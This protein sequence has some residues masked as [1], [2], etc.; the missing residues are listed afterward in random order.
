MRSWKAVALLLLVATAACRDDTVPV[1]FRPEVGAVYRYEVTV[2]SRS[3]V[4]LPGEEPEVHDEEITLQSKQ[5][6]LE[7]GRDGVRVQVILGDA[8]GSVRTFAVRFDRAAQLESVEADDGGEVSDDE[9]GVLGLSEIFPAAAGAPPER[10]LGPGERWTI[11]D[12]VRLPGSSAPAA[13]TGSGRLV[14]LAVQDGEDVARLATTVQLD[15]STEQQTAEGDLV[16]LDG[17][18]RTEQRA[19]HDLDD[20]AV[21]S[22]S[23][24]TEGTYRLHINPPFGQQREPVEGT[25]LVRVTSTTRRLE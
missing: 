2:R 8:S 19:S 11:D 6:V 9:P 10:R 1:T 22:A 15:L 16:R 17:F 5:T 20:G 24:T 18:Q 4:R 12:S 7:A 13:L 23:S 25:L 14:G 3:E 21:R